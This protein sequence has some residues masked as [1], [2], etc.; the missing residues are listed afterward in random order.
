MGTWQDLLYDHII[1]LVLC[2]SL[3]WRVTTHPQHK[4]NIVIQVQW[5][6]VK[7]GIS[8]ST[9]AQEMKSKIKT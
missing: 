7:S 4:Q 1:I 8:S 2:P 3:F 6:Q 5:I 9:Q